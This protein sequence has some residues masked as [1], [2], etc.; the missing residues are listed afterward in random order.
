MSKEI[1]LNFGKYKGQA[2]SKI[3]DTGYLEWLAKTLEPEK[4]NN[5]EIIAAIKV[6]LGTAPAEEGEFDRERSD[7][8]EERGGIDNTPF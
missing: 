2:I 8:E 5:K 1:T 4:F 6:R 7:W 3:K